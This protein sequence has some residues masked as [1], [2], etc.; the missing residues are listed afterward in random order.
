MQSE[1]QRDIASGRIETET[2]TETETDTEAKT[3]ISLAPSDNGSLS[4]GWIV[5]W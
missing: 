4:L 1:P 3:Q 2:E 5:F